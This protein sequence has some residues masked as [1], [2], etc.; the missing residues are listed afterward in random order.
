[1]E[2]GAGTITDA[3][4]TKL[5]ILY[6][7]TMQDFQILHSWHKVRW[8]DPDSPVHIFERISQERLRRVWCTE[9][10][11]EDGW[12]VTLNDVWFANP[13]HATLFALTWL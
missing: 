7:N 3:V 12:L 9:H 5:K 10:L 1:M 2:F 13:A 11:G 6:T 4:D 8:I